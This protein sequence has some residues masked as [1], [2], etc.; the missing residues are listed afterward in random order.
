M[1]PKFDPRSSIETSNRVVWDGKNA[2]N[3][4]VF[5]KRVTPEKS[6]SNLRQDAAIPQRLEEKFNAEGY[7][8]VPTANHLEESRA[9]E[10]KLAMLNDML[11]KKQFAIQ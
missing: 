1:E 5:E 8:A 4:S 2:G 6:N 7:D 3:F 11:K 10:N 9:E